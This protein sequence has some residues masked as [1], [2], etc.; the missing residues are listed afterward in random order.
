MRKA[1]VKTTGGARH[2]SGSREDGYLCREDGC[3]PFR[4]RIGDEYV[5]ERRASWL[6]QKSTL[7]LKRWKHA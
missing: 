5:N 2:R 3:A 4:Q 1:V 6:V 7:G